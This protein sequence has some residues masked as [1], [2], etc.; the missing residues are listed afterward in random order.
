M[1]LIWGIDFSKLKRNDI[2]KEIIKNCFKK[3][4]IIESAG[5]GDLVLKILCPLTISYEELDEGLKII[6]EVIKEVL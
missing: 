3:K 5:R 6:C 1:G 4:L 2:V